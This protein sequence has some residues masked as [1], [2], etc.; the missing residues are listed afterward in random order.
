MALSKPNLSPNAPSC[1]CRSLRYCSGS[2]LWFSRR[3][4]GWRGLLFARLQVRFDSWSGF[5]RVRV[6]FVWCSECSRSETDLFAGFVGL[7]KSC[8]LSL[9]HGSR[10][11]VYQ[12]DFKD[13]EDPK[14]LR[15][16][17]PCLLS[18]DYSTAMAIQVVHSHSKQLVQR[19][20]RLRLL[21]LK[22]CL[23]NR[24]DSNEQCHCQFCWSF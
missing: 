12:R 3:F 7:E 17:G 24:L 19:W 14:T 18:P 10:S 22:A 4:S 6:S 15:I 2:H 1:Y 11:S 9:L 23:W 8:L 20:W 13:L 16:R 5:V 21:Q